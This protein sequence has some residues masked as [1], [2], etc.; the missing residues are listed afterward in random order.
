MI[1]RAAV[2]SLTRSA[3]WVALAVLRLE[4]GF[5][6]RLGLVGSGMYGKLQRRIIIRLFQI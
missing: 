4:P 1:A 3:A 6:S 2:E 5:T